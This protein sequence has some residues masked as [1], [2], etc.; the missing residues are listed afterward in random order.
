[1]LD[2]LLFRSA[3]A[4]AAMMLP[5]ATAQGVHIETV[6]VGNLGNADDT[7]GDGYG[8]VDYAYSI[9]TYEVTAG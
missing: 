7:H 1:M 2:K 9:G 6:P 8:A 5:I 4:L 3:A